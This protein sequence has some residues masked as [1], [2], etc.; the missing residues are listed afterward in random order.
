LSVKDFRDLLGLPSDKLN[1]FK[2][3]KNWA[4]DPAVEE[5][6]GLSDFW[7]GVDA[8]RE[9]GLLRGKLVG[10]RLSWRRKGQGRMAVRAGRAGALESWPQSSNEG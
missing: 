9:G 2:N 5:V 6:N 4:I 10:F 7:V 8:I 1:P 3:L